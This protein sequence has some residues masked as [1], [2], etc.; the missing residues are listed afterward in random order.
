MHSKPQGPNDWYH[1]QQRS[2]AKSTVAANL[3]YWPGE[4]NS[5]HRD[6]ALNGV[7]AIYITS[8]RS[9]MN[10]LPPGKRDNAIRNSVYTI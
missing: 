2:R 9:L 3:I 7:G 10:D 1:Q 8:L 6:L 5:N 4:L